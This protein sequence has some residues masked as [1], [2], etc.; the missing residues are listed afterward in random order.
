MTLELVHK[1][2]NHLEHGVDSKEYIKEYIKDSGNV[3][4]S[5]GVIQAF[6]I[7]FGKDEIKYGNKSKDS[8][9]FWINTEEGLLSY[10]TTT[11]KQMKFLSVLQ[12]WAEMVKVAV[13]VIN[14]FKD[15]ENRSKLLVDHSKFE[16]MGKI[17]FGLLHEINNPLS[18]A[19]LN[20][21]MILDDIDD[22]NEE[23][24][25]MLKEIFNSLERIKKI[26]EIFRGITKKELNIQ[27]IDLIAV[28]KSSI[29][30]V[31]SKVHGKCH[32]NL[33]PDNWEP[34]Y[35]KG[36][37]S[38]LVMMFINLLNNAYE[39]ILE[40]NREK[41][42]IEIGINSFNEGYIVSIKDNGIGMT[43]E[44][45]TRIFEPFYTTKSSTGL[46][47]GLMIVS[48]VCKNHKI[49][50]EVYSRK[51]K[52]SKFVLRIPKDLKEARWNEN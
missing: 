20:A 5:N 4:I 6:Y 9:E 7:K 39:A 34:H 41:G 22:F 37:F 50:I 49:D 30:N 31:K 3:L 10:Y 38:R 15:M 36:D 51:G 42:L 27:R 33:V 28:I 29:D 23:Y 19:W 11:E 1:F 24:K 17:M 26:N 47:Y 35:I 43:R 46:G 13:K 45:I 44:E 8:R 18:V 40:A 14:R 32:I 48:E 25:S 2:L 12:Y 21:Q 16:F 52:G